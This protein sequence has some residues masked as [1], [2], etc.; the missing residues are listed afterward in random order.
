MFH[1]TDYATNDAGQMVLIR[2][3]SQ[4]PQAITSLSRLRVVGAERAFAD[5][6]CPFVERARRRVLALLRQQPRQ[7][8]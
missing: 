4:F 8:V 1:Y 6:Q 2:S 5:R 7:I 3:T